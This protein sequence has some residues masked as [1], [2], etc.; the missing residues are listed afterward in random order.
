MPNETPHEFLRAIDVNT[1]KITWEYPEIGPA[2]S[3]GG[4]L[5]FAS[6]ILIFGADDGVITVLDSSNGKLLW[7]FQTN[8][9]IKASPMTYVFDGK[10]YVAIDA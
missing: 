10:Q 2:N 4:V 3:W 8:V 7:Q 9:Q 6:G 1:G 5:A